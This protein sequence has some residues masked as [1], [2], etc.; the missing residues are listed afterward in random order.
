MQQ[1]KRLEHYDGITIAHVTRVQ[2]AA[3]SR[4]LEW[5]KRTTTKMVFY[6]IFP[7]RSSPK[8]CSRTINPEP[9]GKLSSRTL[10]VLNELLAHHRRVIGKW[11]VYIRCSKFTEAN[12]AG[13][14]SE[15]VHSIHA[16]AIHRAPHTLVCANA[17][18]VLNCIRCRSKEQPS[19]YQHRVLLHQGTRAHRPRT[20]AGWLVS[21]V[22][23]ESRIDARDGEASELDRTRHVH[24]PDGQEAKSQCIAN[25]RRARAR[26]ASTQ[27]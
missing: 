11:S 24:T 13:N 6:R 17:N 22:R 25:T 21:S 10:E 8:H 15:A 4:N 19:Q 27:E 23:E 1:Q 2:N 9:R 12:C 18:A 3:Q 14:R 7:N 5:I 16:N 26:A 20:V